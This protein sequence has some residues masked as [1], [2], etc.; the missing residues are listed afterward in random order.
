MQ[1][2]RAN[3]LIICPGIQCGTDEA[4]AVNKHK[5]ECVKKAEPKYSTAKWVWQLVALDCEDEPQ[6]QKT[7][8]GIAGDF[9][10]LTL[11]TTSPSSVTK[12]A[13]F[14][15]PPTLTLRHT[16]TLEGDRNRYAI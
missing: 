13:S 9:A 1:N 7:A 16:P 12:T 2:K 11:P 8:E 5:L 6:K 4:S 15:F 14:E 3:V 10:V